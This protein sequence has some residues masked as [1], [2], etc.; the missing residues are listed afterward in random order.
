[1]WWWR[2]TGNGK[3]GDGRF[4]NGRKIDRRVMNTGI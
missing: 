4:G 2:W 3:I 1:M